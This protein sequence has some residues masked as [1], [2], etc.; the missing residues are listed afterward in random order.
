MTKLLKNAKPSF[1]YF[2]KLLIN[3]NLD[4]KQIVPSTVVYAFLRTSSCMA[5]MRPLRKAMDSRSSAVAVSGY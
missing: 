1:R 5:G 4:A 2:A 3:V